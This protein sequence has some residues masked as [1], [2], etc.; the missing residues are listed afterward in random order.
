MLSRDI[1]KRTWTLVVE[2]S[3]EKAHIPFR[4]LAERGVEDLSLQVVTGVKSSAVHVLEGNIVSFRRF[5]PGAVA[6]ELHHVGEARRQLHG[7]RKRLRGHAAASVLDSLSHGLLDIEVAYNSQFMEVG[8]S[9]KRYGLVLQNAR[10]RESE[11]LP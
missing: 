10:L 2:H 3:G 1:G 11:G 8:P 9:Q 5:V 4:E 6:Y 7:P